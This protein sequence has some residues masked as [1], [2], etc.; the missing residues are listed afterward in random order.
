MQHDAEKPSAGAMVHLR[1]HIARSCLDGRPYSEARRLV[2]EDQRVK[3]RGQQ[4]S[5]FQKES[6]LCLAIWATPRPQSPCIGAAP[7]NASRRVSIESSLCSCIHTRVCIP[8]MLLSSQ[9]CTTQSRQPTNQV[10]TF[11]QIS[12]I[13]AST[14]RP[15]RTLRQFK[16]LSRSVIIESPLTP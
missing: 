16:L 13:W 7:T 10:I 5:N 2:A 14:N 15:I 12:A 9:G 1:W 6:A 8:S 4:A 11:P 3:A